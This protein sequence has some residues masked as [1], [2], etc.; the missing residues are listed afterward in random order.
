MQA[1]SSNT[2]VNEELSGDSSPKCVETIHLQPKSEMIWLR[3]SPD[4]NTEMWLRKS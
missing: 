2:I 4:H 1:N 3:N